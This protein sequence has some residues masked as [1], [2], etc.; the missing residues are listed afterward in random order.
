[1]SNGR[2][3]FL[4]PSINVTDMRP[5]DTGFLYLADHSIPSSAEVMNAWSFTSNHAYSF[6]GR[7]GF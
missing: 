3:R 1:M 5:S 6:K 2:P 4:Y 7:C